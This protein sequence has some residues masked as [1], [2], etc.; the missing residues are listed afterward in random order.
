MKKALIVCLREGYIQIEN[1]EIEEIHICNRFLQLVEYVA[2]V[3]FVS[4]GLFVGASNAFLMSFQ[5]FYSIL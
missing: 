5:L 4:K 1:P 2:F 3:G